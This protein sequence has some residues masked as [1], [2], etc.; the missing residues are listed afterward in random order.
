[1]KLKRLFL[2]VVL[3]LIGFIAFGCGPKATDTAPEILGA[4]DKTIEKGTRF[5]P[6]EGITA[7]D[8]EDGDL[9]EEIQVVNKVNINVEGT[10]K[11][12]YT[13][14][15][16]D[17]NMAKQEIT[18]TVVFTD[19]VKPFI[20]GVNNQTLYV[21]QS[22]DIL[23]GVTASDNIDGNVTS[24]IVTE[25][26]VDVWTP[27]KYTV[28]YKVADSKGN[29]AT[30]TR[31]VEVT[32]GLFAF[33]E[34]VL[35]SS[36]VFASG[37]LSTTVSSG[38]IFTLIETFG[39]AKLTFKAKADAATELTYSLAGAT[40]KGTVA[41]TTELQEYT[42][43]FNY[44]EELKDA[45][46]SLAAGN[47]AVVSDLSLQFA[48]AR[49]TVLPV[50]EVPADYN[51]VLPGSID[52]VET[53]KKYALKGIT[54]TDN[55]DGNRTG[56]LD[57][58]FGDLEL[59]NVFGKHT[60]TVFVVDSSE[61]RAEAEIEIEFTKAVDT[62]IIPNSDFSSSDVSHW[63]INNANDLYYMEAVLE[64]D[65]ESQSL[66]HYN[67]TSTGGAF[68][69]ANCP[70][71]KTT[72]EHL[73]VG[74]WYMLEFKAKAE[75]E[76]QMRVRIGIDAPSP[77][78]I[79]DF[80][81]PANVDFTL[82]TEY[83]TYR[84]I[85][86]VN[87][88]TSANNFSNKVKLEIKLGRYDGNL[89]REVNNKVNI[90]DIQYY[91]L[92]NDD[93][94]PVLTVDE[95][96]ATTFPKGSNLS[97]LT[98]LVKAWD[99]EDGAYVEITS[100][101]IDTSKVDAN[102]PG[103]Y[104]VT[105]NVPD[106]KGHVA[107]LTVNIRI[108]AEADTTKPVLTA[109]KTTVEIDQFQNLILADL[110]TANDNIDGNI[111]IKAHMISSEFN[112]KVAGTYTATYTVKDSSGNEETLT[113]TIIVKD[114]EAP[115]I[116]GPKS[117]SLE[118][119]ETLDFANLVTVTDNVDKD[120]DFAKVLVSGYDGYLDATG[121]ATATGSFT[122]NFSYTD[123]N[124]NEGTLEV[125]V[126]VF[127]A[128]PEETKLEDFE[129]FADSAA[130]NN[131]ENPLKGGW[132]RRRIPYGKDPADAFDLELVEF[133]GGKAVQFGYNNSGQ[134]VLMY[135]FAEGETYSG[136]Y[137]Y[138][139]FK[140]NTS[141]EKI[142]F[143]FVDT[144]GKITSGP[145]NRY[146]AGTYGINVK[147]LV[148][149]HGYYY[150]DLSMLG[151]T[152]DQASAF[153]WAMNYQSGS[154]TIIDDVSFTKSCPKM[155]KMEV[156][157]EALDALANHGIMYSGVSLA[158]LFTQLKSAIKITNDGE[159]VALTDDMIDFGGLN[160]ENPAAGNYTVSIT[161]TNTDGV[162][163]STE[164]VL[165]VTPAGSQKPTTPEDA[166]PM[167]IIGT[168]TQSSVYKANGN[169]ITMT[170]LAGLGPWIRFDLNPTA[171]SYAKAVV[172]VRGTGIGLQPKLD[173]STN[174]WDG[175]AGNKKT[176][177]VLEEDGYTV[178]EWD[179]KEVGLDS[180]QIVKL[181]FWAYSTKTANAVFEVVDA[182]YLP[183]GSSE[184]EEPENPEFTLPEN[185]VEVTP[186][187]N[188]TGSNIYTISGNKVTI[189]G[190]N[191]QSDKWGRWDFAN[192]TEQYAK[193]V[194]VLKGTGFALGMKV[195]TTTPTNN[196]YDGVK[197]NKTYKALEAS[198]Y[199]VFEWDLAALN[200]DSTKL[201]KVVFWAYS[202]TVTE[203]EFELVSIYYLPAE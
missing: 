101:M 196:A 34:N 61:N 144:D 189:S 138:I 87:K 125:K 134:Y 107:T 112:N 149:A 66:V 166:V 96:A 160:P 56:L 178:F 129:G 20:L 93:N 200:I 54:A 195:D 31:E 60:V 49:D 198:G 97:G 165:L 108:L 109:E 52:D 46:L 124:G 17:G 30:A 62:N 161:Y 73:K 177:V 170:G 13:V 99:M 159:S 131:E 145:D 113:I 153:G 171:E 158:N 163:V 154:K 26:T 106:S 190:M 174:G 9:T 16:S 187:G 157:Q 130:L 84:V 25:G 57:I 15:D 89:E 63:F 27:G 42:V 74:N 126:K 82:T 79:D 71:F 103:T 51:C 151:V 183:S 6:L 19:D 115:V 133:E 169:V 168:Y 67:T 132:Y 80:L 123:A 105:Y 35:T 41:L 11:V 186:T 193:I 37:A 142:R 162:A 127:T 119:G 29:E 7:S 100:D 201:Q 114:K 202:S 179:M 88:E 94:A 188:S 32:V 14:F 116:A 148:Y 117:A 156:S 128:S 155:P 40:C 137:R 185:A 86:F 192:A 135:K 38:E 47:N 143:W 23:E 175:N 10:Y 36:D 65:S 48:S 110:V 83:K 18:V 58:D 141:A 2:L 12:T 72:T 81:S 85:F 102:T 50:I 136:N 3:A 147:D 194:V 28:N 22:F 33:G 182:Y 55:V 5:L 95:N 53:L 176:G 152:L 59:G 118:V 122:L 184:P 111:E 76:R 39:L 150:F 121:K 92:T 68:D 77:Q 75:V 90:D 180:K 199:T 120:I 44:T 24:K 146:G 197:G 164:F 91:L 4:V 98:N 43:Y 1:M 78:W 69:S 45:A 172:V 70:C 104:E 203:G 139:K 181:V 21:G 167:S 173:N 191:S 64:Y 8:K 140:M